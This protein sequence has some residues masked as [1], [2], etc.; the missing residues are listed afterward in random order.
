MLYLS[1]SMYFCVTFLCTLSFCL[2]NNVL[3]ICIKVKVHCEEA[4][5]MAIIARDIKISSVAISYSFRN[6]ATFMKGSAWMTPVQSVSALEN[7]CIATK[8]KW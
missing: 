6:V 4:K 7:H 5:M 3:E 1:I 2:I 8:N